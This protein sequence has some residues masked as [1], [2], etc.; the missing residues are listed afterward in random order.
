MLSQ[1]GL[2]CDRRAELSN[3]GFRALHCWTIAL[4]L[5]LLLVTPAYATDE[6]ECSL[7]SMEEGVER[8]IIIAKSGDQVADHA[9]YVERKSLLQE[10]HLFPAFYFM[11]GKGSTNACAFPDKTDP[12]RGTVTFGEELLRR[13]VSAAGGPEYASSVPAIM[14]H[15]FGHLLQIK[16][17]N[18]ATGS[19]YELQADYIAGWYMGRRTKLVPTTVTSQQ[20]LET[21]MR[22]FYDKGDYQLND[23]SHHGTP[24][25]RVAAISA[26]YRNSQLSIPDMYRESLKYVSEGTDN[27]QPDDSNTP[28]DPTELSSG[29]AEV[30]K[31][32]ANKFADLRGNLDEDSKATW[33]ATL[34][35]PGADRCV[36]EWRNQYQGNYNCDMT[37]S[38]DQAM[39][40]DS[41]RKLVAVV[42]KRYAK[43]WKRED[44]NVGTSKEV[45]FTN[46]GS[47]DVS[48]KVGIAKSS[49]HRGYDV[50]IELPFDDY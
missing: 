21:I 22:S 10:F 6:S 47:D 1:V 11:T 32:Q 45:V 48:V 38:L 12:D 46:P 44:R 24:N 39:A 16:N 33:I 27:T 15:E 26:G 3:S 9:M 35:L 36:V 19:K 5:S 30:M 4:F 20:S 28:Y 43:G 8:G 34:K 2:Q 41:W 37:V 40:E 18:T 29:L 42:Q 50:E 13:E 14:A 7:S 25:E 49:L 23:P 31:H 17:G